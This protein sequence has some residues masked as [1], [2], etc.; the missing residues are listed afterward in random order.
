MSKFYQRPQKF[1]LCIDWE[2]SG[3]TWG[4]DSS[5]DYQGLSFGAIV[6]DTDTFTEIESIHHHVKFDETKYKWSDDAQ[7]I[8]GLTREF[9]EENGL[10]QEEAATALLELIAKYFAGSKVMFLG[11]NP[12]FDQRFTNQLLNT[13][14]AEFTTE[15]QNEEL[16][17]IEL[18]HVMLDTSALGFITLGLYKS[19]ALFERMGFEERGDHSALVDARQTLGT[20]SIIKQLIKEVMQ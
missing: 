9:L 3:A 1:G 14:G 8:H 4:G 7:K 6:F 16:V 2:T 12:I 20:C 10:T 18:H 17:Q 19:D 5:K 15:R 13:V 11:H